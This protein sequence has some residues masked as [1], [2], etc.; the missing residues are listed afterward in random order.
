MQRIDPLDDGPSAG[1]P[2]RA[3][4]WPEIED[5]LRAR[6]ADRM[7]H[8]G[9]TLLHHLRRVAQLLGDWG[10]DTTVQIAGLCH[11]AY[12]TDGFAPTLLDVTERPALS[13]LIGERAEALV[14]LYASCDRGVVYPRFGSDRPVLFRDR[15]TGQEHTPPEPDLRAFLEITAANEL[16]VLTHHTDLARRH[17]PSLYRLFTR[18][19]DLLSTAAQEA[20]E[21]HLGRYADGA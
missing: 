19:Y 18:S 15:C 21:H 16:D 14:Y 13:Q 2:G 20:C 17:G 4:A 11:A 7:P 3:T 6:G 1:G 10:A 8:P 5:F 9:G 12:G